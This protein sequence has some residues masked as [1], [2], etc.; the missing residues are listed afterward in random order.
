MYCFAEQELRDLLE[1]AWNQDCN[2]QANHQGYS[3]LV[4]DDKMRGLKRPTDQW[5]Q[6]KQDVENT[7]TNLTP[8]HQDY[9][10][11]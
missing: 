3:W 9:D 4:L 6:I 8:V 11:N 5:V 7:L 1:Q 10:D 2:C